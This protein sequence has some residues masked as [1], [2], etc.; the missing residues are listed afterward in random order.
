MPDF[1]LTFG[2]GDNV[3]FANTVLANLINLIGLDA[4]K[5]CEQIWLRDVKF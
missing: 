4:L 5:K 2:A 3:F 1:T